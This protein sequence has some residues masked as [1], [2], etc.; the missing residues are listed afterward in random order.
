MSEQKI[1][2]GTKLEEG[3]LGL[4]RVVILLVLTAS[5]IAAVYFA[6]SGFSSMK[7]QPEE[8]KYEQFNG[9]S[10]VKEIK[11]QFDDAKKVPADQ[12]SEK[13]K[14]QDKKVNKALED[15]LNKQIS[16][17]KEFLK[18]SDR[19]LSDEK[20]FKNARRNE[21]L[22]LAFDKSDKGVAEYAVG[23]TAFF[24]LVF[25]HPD[26]LALEQKHRES[27]S[28]D[29]LQTFFSAALDFY[30]NFYREQAKKKEIFESDQLVKVAEAKENSMLQLYMAA[31]FFGAFLLISLILVLVKIERDLRFKH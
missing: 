29:F 10:F 28:G 30:P 16:I 18:R 20:A 14:D 26:I 24:G 21:A 3:F 22:T 25:K 23:Q 2:L 5:L 13:Q 11:D 4:L 1:G 12:E 8:Y 9:E 31:G 17:I 27:E 7:A 15:E 19:S 6:F